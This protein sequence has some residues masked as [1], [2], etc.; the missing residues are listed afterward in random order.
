MT[1]NGIPDPTAPPHEHQAHTIT[2]ECIIC[3]LDM[4]VPETTKKPMKHSKEYTCLE[5]NLP[6]LFKVP[7]FVTYLNN[8]DPRVQPALATWHQ[9]GEPGE[10]SDVFIVFDHGHGVNSDM[11]GWDIITAICDA[12]GMEF[13]IVR[14]TNLELGPEVD[15]EV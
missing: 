14:I 13:G 12:A 10:T 5:V 4:F 1:Y 3:G 9:G 6:S 11:P 15:T 8:D 2:H 7:E